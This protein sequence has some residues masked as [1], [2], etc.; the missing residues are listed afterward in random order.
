MNKENENDYR[1]NVAAVIVSS[2]YPKECN[3][4]IAE[5]SDIPGAWQFP[6][7]GVDEGES[8]KDALFRELKEEIGCNNIEILTQYPEWISYD[9]PSRV[10]K[11]MYPYRGQKQQYYLVRLKAGATINI[12]TQHPEFTSYKFVDVNVLFNHI[13]YFKRPIYKKVINYFRKEGFL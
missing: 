3:I 4:F 9:F 11:K 1:P 10:A 12:E 5:R 2:E 6:Q 7:G 8:N 13:T